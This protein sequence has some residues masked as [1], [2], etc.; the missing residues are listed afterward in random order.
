MSK[1]YSESTVKVYTSLLNKLYNAGF[2]DKDFQNNPKKVMSWIEKEASS[3]RNIHTILNHF[4]ALLWKLRTTYNGNGT[5]EIVK[6]FEQ[7]RPVQ[8]EVDTSQKLPEHRKDKFLP[9]SEVIGLQKKAKDSF[10]DENY[11]IYCLYTMQ[12]PARA[13]YNNMYITTRMSKNLSDDKNWLLISKD[14]AKWKFIFNDFK[15]A[16]T[17][18][19]IINK[20][21]KELVEVLKEYID[22]NNLQHGNKLLP[23]LNTDNALVKRVRSIFKKLSDKEVGIGLLRHAYVQHF[24]STKKTFKQREDLAKKMMHSASLQELYDIIPQD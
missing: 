11:I 18:G 8:R 19:Q 24:L 21:P 12:P 15:T 2:T 17:M 5:E 4:K 13:D 14:A 9:W 1:Q 20:V 6:R 7:L 16:T 23:T 22:A 10:T 3:K